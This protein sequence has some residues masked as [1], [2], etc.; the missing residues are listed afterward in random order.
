[1][2]KDKCS[3]EVFAR[4]RPVKRPSANFDIDYASHALAI[5]IPREHTNNHVNNQREN[6]NFSFSRILD[7]SMQ[8][9]GVFESVAQPVVDSVLEGYNGTVFAYGQTGS[10]KTFTITGGA[11]KYADRGMIP[12]SISY[13]FQ[14]LKQRT[15]CHFEVRIS[16]LEIYNENGYDLLDPSHETKGLE[17][18]PKVTLMED[19]D[20][21]IHLK[22]L[23]GQLAQSEEEAL[24]YLFVGDTNRMISETPMNLASS[25]SHCIFTISIAARKPD[26]DVVRKSKLHMV[27][28]AGSERVKKTGIEG[29]IL[30]EAKYINLSLHFLEQVIIAVRWVGLEP[31][32]H[33]PANLSRPRHVEP[34]LPTTQVRMFWADLVRIPPITRQLGSRDKFVPYRNSMMTSVSIGYRVVSE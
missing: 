9:D 33:S 5:T 13:I 1:M 16:Y 21:K 34:I 17:D 19:D 3:I 26:S 14:T 10:G 4:V 24:N 30:R 32:R 20:G 12:R 22:N 31:T 11:E 15:D 23:S 2:T 6:Y 28:L 18:L 29:T 7:S 27:D 8:Q 25:R